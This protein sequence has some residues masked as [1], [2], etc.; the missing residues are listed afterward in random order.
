MRQPR[1]LILTPALADAN[2]GNWHT[3]SRW[4]RF[5][6]GRADVRIGREW[7]GQP[8]DA[9]IALHA[10]RSAP[11]IARYAATHPGRPLAV[12]LT[13]TDLYRDLAVGD[14]GALHSLQCASHLVVLQPTALQRLNAPARAKARVVLQ[15]APRLVLPRQA[16]DACEL[17]AVGHL[18]AEKDPLTLMAAMRLLP[19]A[20]PLR[21]THVGSALDPVLGEAARRTMAQ[22][23][24]Y[25]WLGALAPEAARER[26]AGAS[27]LVHASRLE[28]GPHVVIEAVRSD[29]PVLV[30][31]IDG[32]VGLLG[33]MYDGYFA[34]GDAEALAALMQRFAADAPFARR[35]V[36]QCAALAPLFEPATEAAAV[37][38]LLTDMLAAPGS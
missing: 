14:T 22:C 29:V 21:L 18:R 16:R 28:G 19:E 15:S 11:S 1:V 10:R 9:L 34:P 7:D 35:L 20:A 38:R 37:R 6:A 5:L 32:H 26:I 27:A 13:G 30:S 25:C 36:G 31:R 3:A 12:V 4:Q 24:R 8:P 17:V 33:E 23:P 2:N